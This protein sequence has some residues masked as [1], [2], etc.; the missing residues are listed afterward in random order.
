MPITSTQIV[1]REAKRLHRAASSDSLSSA[2]P[3]L[4]R[5][6]AAGAMP[7]V[8]LPELFRRRS[9]VQ[10]KNI[11]RMLAIEAG[12]QSWEDYRPKLELVDA[13]H[14][15][16]FEILDKGYANLNLWFSNK[17]EAQLFAREN[18][19][20]V[21]IVGGQAVVLPVS[22]SESSPKQGAWYD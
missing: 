9:T 16:S 3:V 21:V 6:I 13:K 17:A 8:S 19:G 10:R 4:R 18:G 12:D 1:L 14:F 20:R 5:L 22:E 7:N 11:L 2:L 15:E